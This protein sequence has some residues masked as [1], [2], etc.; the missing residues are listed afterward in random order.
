MEDKS[1]TLGA[2][3]GRNLADE[4]RV[5]PCAMPRVMQAFEPGY[6]AVDQ[7]RIRPS[8]PVA[9]A[10]ETVLMG[11]GEPARELGLL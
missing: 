3:A 4:N 1:A 11:P 8:H 7:R 6:A 10:G 9:D 2:L 5:I